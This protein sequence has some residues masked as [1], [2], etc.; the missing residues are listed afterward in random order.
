ML[1]QHLQTIN[2]DWV[3]VLEK[4]PQ[5][6]VCI[7][8]LILSKNLLNTA[9]TSQRAKRLLGMCSSQDSQLAAVLI[10][11]ITSKHTKMEVDAF[12]SS[13]N[14]DWMCS[15]ELA[16]VSGF[17]LRVYFYNSVISDESAIF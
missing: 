2:Q 14:M 4:N 16:Q 5:Y 13:S 12:E 8:K 7:F 1:L 6:S 15:N 17:S 3:Q 10:D 11:F 9:A